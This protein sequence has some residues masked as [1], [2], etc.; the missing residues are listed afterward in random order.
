MSKFLGGDVSLGKVA[1]RRKGN[2]RARMDGLCK[3]F[4]NKS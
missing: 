4:E 2:E 1:R 3:A